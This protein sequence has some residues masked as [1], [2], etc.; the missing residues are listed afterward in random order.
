MNDAGLFGRSRWIDSAQEAPK[1]GYPALQGELQTGDLWFSAGQCCIS[2]FL[3]RLGTRSRWVHVGM[4]LREQGDLYLIDA[5][6]TGSLRKIRIEEALL[7]NRVGKSED[8]PAIVLAR[9]LAFVGPG[10]THALPGPKVADFRQR[11]HN[12]VA[13]GFPADYDWLEILRIVLILVLGGLAR[14]WRY[15]PLLG[16]LAAAM[17]ARH[18]RRLSAAAAE[19]NPPSGTWLRWLGRRCLLS[20]AGME[21]RSKKQDPYTCAELVAELLGQYRP[22][23]K[24]L[25]LAPDSDDFLSPAVIAERIPLVM[26]GRLL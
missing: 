18:M 9:P 22:Y 24:E 15:R 20:P 5:P 14:R 16:F 8:P 17:P 23:R 13:Q 7:E 11:I 25:G 10:H 26:L 3:I 1:T 21:R 6:A 12:R 2:H 4:V 19:R